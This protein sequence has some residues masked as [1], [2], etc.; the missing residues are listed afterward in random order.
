MAKSMA[1]IIKEQV[2]ESSGGSKDLPKVTQADTKSLQVK[3]DS[4][5]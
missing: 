4:G 2:Q 1:D 5:C 3:S